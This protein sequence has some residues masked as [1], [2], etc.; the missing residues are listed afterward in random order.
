M[1][2]EIRKGEGKELRNRDIGRDD[3]LVKSEVHTDPP[4]WL[5]GK[6][7]PESKT[8]ACMTTRR[9]GNSGSP[10]TALERESMP[11]NRKKGGRQNGCR[12][13]DRPVVPEKAGNA[14]GGKGETGG[15]AE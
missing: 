10:A 13:S 2:A 11:D 3:D 5:G 15:R 14:A 9:H 7:S 8:L 6:A 12:E 4:E 1:Q